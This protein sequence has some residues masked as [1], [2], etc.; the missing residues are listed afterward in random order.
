MDYET[1]IVMLF[2]HN[3]QNFIIRKHFKFNRVEDETIK[4]NE[5]FKLTLKNLIVRKTNLHSI[6]A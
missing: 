2:S 3:Q 4:P 6:T 1:L 5:H